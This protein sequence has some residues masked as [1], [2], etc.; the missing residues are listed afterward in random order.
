MRIFGLTTRLLSM[1]FVLSAAFFSVTADAAVVVT[2]YPGAVCVAVSGGAYMLFGGTVMN[3]SSTS[4][5][6]VM[7]PLV[8]DSSHGSLAGATI[9]VFDRNSTRDVSCTLFSETV[10]GST[11]SSF[12]NTQTSSG[13]GSSVQTLSFPALGA[14]QH[15]FVTC[16]IPRTD[17]GNVSH[18]GNILIGQ[19]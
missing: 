7:C 13:F 2:N 4:E 1:P 17:G 14:G 16:S 3:A 6:N 12:S 9:W 8:N 15:Y 19:G 5:L 18:V 10:S 11:V